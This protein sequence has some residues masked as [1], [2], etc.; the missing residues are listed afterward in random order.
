MTRAAVSSAG[1]SWLSGRAASV[2]RWYGRNSYEVYLT[3]MFA[4]LW[5]L[6]LFRKLEAPMNFA[7]LCFLG[8]L[9]VAGLLGAAVAKWFSEPLN[10]SLRKNLSAANANPSA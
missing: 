3:H 8:I 6:Q 7:P 4:V 10:Q 2:I 5:G 9:I 1:K